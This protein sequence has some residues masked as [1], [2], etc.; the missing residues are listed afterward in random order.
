MSSTDLMVLE[1]Y[2]VSKPKQNTEHLA[3]RTHGSSIM[4]SMLDWIK[5]A[6]THTAPN[7]SWWLGPRMC[8]I[9]FLGAST[10]PF[11]IILV[12]HKLEGELNLYL[13][14]FD[15]TSCQ[16]RTSNWGRTIFWHEYRTKLP[17]LTCVPIRI[18][19]ET[20]RWSSWEIVVFHL[21]EL[22]SCY[23]TF[24]QSVKRSGS[25]SNLLAQRVVYS[26]TPHQ[27]TYWH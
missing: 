19:E 9:R 23:W 8:K 14:I 15:N 4:T 7:T 26:I 22:G 25:S 6:T 10:A 18:W 21:K 1:G 12:F 13:E 11:S 2:P 24:L 17:L 5:M 27:P 16:K 20:G 3:S